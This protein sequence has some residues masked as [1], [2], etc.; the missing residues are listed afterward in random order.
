MK[1][2]A[3]WLERIAEWIM[4]AMLA[5]MVVLVFGNV[6]LRYVFHSGIVAAEEL[7]RLFF[8]WLIFIGATIGLRR[9]Q[10]LGIDFV[11]ARLPAPLRRACAV[12]AHALM[13]YALWLFVDG[14]WSQLLIGTGTYS[15]VL[16]FPMA[17][18]SAAGFFPAVA[19]TLIVL[20]NLW[21]IVLGEP[22]ARIP[23]QPLPEGN[24]SGVALAEH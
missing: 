8:V 10:H 23:G 14:S 15:T 7:A 20:A 18:Y 2:M 13:L 1:G 6:V 9:Q 3:D 24:R 16:G 21:R 4:A 17:F 5:G 11:Q 22:E 19:M 12:V